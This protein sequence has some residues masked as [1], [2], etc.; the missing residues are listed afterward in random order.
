MANMMDK[1]E[2]I[3]LSLKGVIGVMGKDDQEKF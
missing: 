2:Y 3:I 1:I